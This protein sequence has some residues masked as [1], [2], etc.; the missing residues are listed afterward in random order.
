MGRSEI[1]VTVGGEECTERTSE[2][3]DTNTT[4]G[5]RPTIQYITYVDKL[6]YPILLPQYVC[7]PPN[8]LPDDAPVVV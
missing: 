2:D 1:R 6:N 8:E 4:V 7:T 3:D 5:A